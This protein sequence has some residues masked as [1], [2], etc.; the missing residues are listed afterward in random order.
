[1]KRLF[2]Y[3]LYRTEKCR[4]G[5]DTVSVFVR[6]RMLRG[7][8]SYMGVQATNAFA[9]VLFSII[10]G[11]LYYVFNVDPCLCENPFVNKHPYCTAMMVFTVVT[12]WMMLLLRYWTDDVVDTKYEELSKIYK[13]EEYSDFKKFLV[14]LF[15]CIAD[16]LFVFALIFIAVGADSISLAMTI[17]H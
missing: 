17:F 6:F 11:L 8:K 5:D 7:G 10:V 12:T 16:L 9:E 13:E 1:M 14:F 4:R 2:Y 3:V 15:L